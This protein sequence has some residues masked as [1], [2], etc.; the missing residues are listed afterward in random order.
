MKKIFIITILIITS[1]TNILLADAGLGIF[2]TGG[3]ATI[4]SP[5]LKSYR[6]IYK[7][8]NP[9][10]I[11]GYS[12][13]NGYAFSIGARRVDSE[14]P[15][16]FGMSYNRSSG[17]TSAKFD[18]NRTS[19]MTYTE[20]SLGIDIG[21]MMDLTDKLM[22]GILYGGN[23]G[24]HILKTTQTGSVTSNGNYKTLISSYMKAGIEASY[25]F[26]K[27]ANF[28]TKL[29]FPFSYGAQGYFEDDSKPIGQERL[30]I[31]PG[32]SAGLYNGT[33]VKDDFG[34]WQFQFGILIQGDRNAK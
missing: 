22:F 33:Y 28:Y 31:T 2:V 1:T 17:S 12:P 19:K 14:L 20:N 18:N 7:T 29:Y 10:V 25:R 24:S 9:G 15:Y 23:F 30:E 27:T 3:I 5:T 16:Y 4:S 11:S 13:L 26:G 21:A 6:N 8:G 32:F 34:G